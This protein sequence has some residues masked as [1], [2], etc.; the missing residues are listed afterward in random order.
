MDIPEEDLQQQTAL[1]AFNFR[2][3]SFP[4]IKYLLSYSPLLTRREFDVSVCEDMLKQQNPSMQT[5]WPRIEENA[6][7]MEASWCKGGL[8]IKNRYNILEPISTNIIEPEQLDV[9]FIP[10]VAFDEKGYRVGYGKG[11]YDRYLA[12]CRHDI[13]RVGFSF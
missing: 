4:S 8:F 6:A 10:L 12:R 5:A 2:K 7:D 3:L 13:I 11:Y 9:I 1:M